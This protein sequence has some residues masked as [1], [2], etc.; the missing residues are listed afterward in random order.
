MTPI[1][2]IHGRPVPLSTSL[3]SDAPGHTVNND[4]S[5]SLV[6]CWKCHGTGVLNV[7]K[8]QKSNNNKT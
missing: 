7:N 2:P 1:S 8:K 3:K 4:K 6:N 5:T